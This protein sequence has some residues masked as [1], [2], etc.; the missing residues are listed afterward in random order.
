[1]EL[2]FCLT[3]VHFQH[4]IILKNVKQ[5]CPTVNEGERIM[6][7]WDS[8]NMKR[9]I[10]FTN[11]ITQNYSNHI[12]LDWILI[13]WKISKGGPTT[14]IHKQKTIW[15]SGKS[16]Q[17]KQTYIHHWF[18]HFKVWYKNG[19]C[20]SF[21]ILRLNFFFHFSEQNQKSLNR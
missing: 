6:G 16:T 2:K 18:C 13:C 12:G 8:T 20:K 1:M 11:Q 19:D 7:I 4:L 3:L 5:D 15:C 21:Q 17:G 10:P 9:H 14:T